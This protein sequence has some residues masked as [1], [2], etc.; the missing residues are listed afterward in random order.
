MVRSCLY[1]YLAQPLGTSPRPRLTPY[2]AFRSDIIGLMEARD[3]SVEFWKK[4]PAI[5]FC[6]S[7][8]PQSIYQSQN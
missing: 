5:L 8:L 1:L 4:G 6:R 7:P 2:L 3:F